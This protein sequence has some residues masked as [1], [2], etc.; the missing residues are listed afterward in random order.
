MKAGKHKNS[1]PVKSLWKEFKWVGNL[2]SGGFSSVS[3]IKSENSNIYFAAKCQQTIDPQTRSIARAE[4]KILRKFEECQY[5]V[6]LV[7]FFEEVTSS[8]GVDSCHRPSCGVF[9]NSI[10]VTELLAGGDLWDMLV[11]R[12]RMITEL[13]CKMILVQ[14]LEALKFI[15]AMEIVHMDVKLSNIMF[16]TS[17][18]N[19][20]C[21]KLIDF[22]LAVDLKQK[23]HVDCHGRGTADFIA[24]EVANE[25]LV[26]TV[27]DTWSLGV[28]L[29]M[30]L[31][32]G[33]APVYQRSVG[34][35]QLIT[36][37]LPDI[38]NGANLFVCHLLEHDFRK[39]PSAEDSLWNQWLTPSRE[40]MRLGRMLR[41]DS[42]MVR[43]FQAR[44]RWKNLV[45]C[46]R[47]SGDKKISEN[48]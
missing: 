14:V 47:L 35:D 43:R 1:K 48:K 34:K 8:C 39:R 38:S 9:H 6:Q 11:F 30:L 29:H 27:S 22:G 40:M 17:N 42:V 7:D 45:Q 46:V 32:G 18:H 19:N 25:G 3:L 23:D 44:K 10:I 13:R 26:T 31:S 16:T 4:V 2:G 24:P 15:H 21:V 28:V 33:M 5:I 41:T 12:G 37:Y 36:T 20:L